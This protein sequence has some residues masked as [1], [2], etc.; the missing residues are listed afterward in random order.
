MTNTEERSDEHGQAPEYCACAHRRDQHN[1]A[2]CTVCPTAAIWDNATVGWIN[3]CTKF[4]RQ[5]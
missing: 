2:G 4:I 5:P 1:E 3:P